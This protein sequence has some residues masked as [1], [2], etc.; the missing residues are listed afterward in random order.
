MSIL[1]GW[2][3]LQGIFLII[4]LDYMKN[5]FLISHPSSIVVLDAGRV[6]EF[7]PPNQL[8]SNKKSAFYS[9][10]KDAGLVG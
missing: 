7:S 8:L 10:A 3:V 5:N 6:A 9:M 1:M 4:V 2:S